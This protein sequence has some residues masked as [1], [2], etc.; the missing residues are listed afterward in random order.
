MYELFAREDSSTPAMRSRIAR[1]SF[2]AGEISRALK[3]VSRAEEAYIHAIALQERLSAGYPGVPAYREELAE[4]RNWLG[5]L[6]RTE[7]RNLG[8]AER[9][10]REALAL[11]T[12]LAN[13]FSG[14]PRYRRL[15]ARSLFN[16]GIVAMDT[17]RR[18][19][20]REDY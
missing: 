5:E 1:A 3:D 19:A 13:S 10:Y 12:E 17:G 6:H 4:S 2:R 9:S 14:E 20:A 7:G 8:E 18:L 16:L 11:Q 15:Q